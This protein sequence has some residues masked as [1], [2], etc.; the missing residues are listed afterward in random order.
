MA[1]AAPGLDDRIGEGSVRGLSLPRREPTPDEDSPD[2]LAEL[3]SSFVEP[4]REETDQLQ[5][6]APLTEE[7]A[8]PVESPPP[9][10]DADDMPGWLRDISQP[11]DVTDTSVEPGASPAV[12]GVG[13]GEIPTWLQEA[14]E[15]PDS[16]PDS[17][18]VD[19]DEVPE[20]MADLSQETDQ[21]T[22]SEPG[23]LPS[24]LQEA[25]PQDT[26]SDIPGAA[27]RQ[28]GPESGELPERLHEAKPLETPPDPQPTAAVDEG[29]DIEPAEL[30][31]WLREVAPK[32]TSPE[33]APAAGM[34]VEIEPGELPDWLQETLTADDTAIEPDELPDWLAQIT[35]EETAPEL[36]LAADEDT[37][38]EP[39]EL[40]DWLEKITPETEPPQETAS[41]AGDAETESGELPAW[42]DKIAPQET[43]PH[44][45][46]A[47]DEEREIEP[48]ELPDWLEKSEYDDTAPDWPEPLIPDADRPDRGQ[49]PKE[50][51]SEKPPPPASTIPSEADALT[52]WL[53]ATAPLADSQL[54]PTQPMAGTGPLVPP[55]LPDWL[56]AVDDS[57]ATR[58]PEWLV[59]EDDDSIPPAAASALPTPGRAQE[60]LRAPTDAAPQE[61]EA[62]SLPS[63]LSQTG[64]GFPPVDQAHALKP[65]AKT[66]EPSIAG[67]ATRVAPAGLPD[68]LAS[69]DSLAE[70]EELAEET[71][72]EAPDRPPADSEAAP[73][74]PELAQA[75]IPE[76]LQALKPEGFVEDV[77]GAAGAAGLEP[78]ETDGLLQGVRGALVA[79]A[80]VTAPPATTAPSRLAV[81][82]QQQ[83]HTKALE[84]IVRPGL[85]PKPPSTAARPAWERLERAAIPIV[86]FLAILLPTFL[87]GSPLTDGDASV[88]PPPGISDTF[89][90]IELMPDSALAVVAFDYSPAEA[91]ELEPLSSVLVR[92][93]MSRGE[94]I[95]AVSTT[96]TGSEIAQGVLDKLSD[97]YGYVYGTDYL[98]LGYIPGGAAGLQAF[99]AA[100]WRLF[101]GADYLRITR[102]SRAAQAASSL[103]DS[104]ADADLILI[105]T[106]ARD[107]LA[108]WIEQ[109]GRL[110]DME[111]VGMAAGVS[112][113]LEPWVRP[114]YQSDSP[115]LSGLV[116]GIPGASQYELLINQQY[117]LRQSHAATNVRDGQMVGL[118]AVSLV[119]AAGLVWGTASALIDRRRGNG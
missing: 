44:I 21:D 117:S 98:N 12:P 59:E 5:A 27:D 31:D 28:G 67:G 14:L 96:P 81:T 101:S 93:L 102:S 49:L 109:V 40:P 13:A 9:P 87:G 100:P 43:Q 111:K 85:A 107:D 15:K 89:N 8:S 52:D 77:A 39:D 112:A 3:R 62:D 37:E 115:Q 79:E 56:A 58:L 71:A 65:I 69:L 17:R 46:P 19:D 26:L 1:P 116:S 92:H 50:D 66:D 36:E 33:L 90:L 94:R 7:G 73:V 24:W 51:Q 45:P 113:G 34:G 106:A 54:A 2:W 114:Y 32:E 68:W 10:A 22:E 11:S 47:T 60:A 63:W 4:E 119:I 99:A 110:P 48:G 78:V 20:W 55:E 61:E 16:A 95:L 76:W 57:A 25:R 118:A 75:A 104:L 105:V 103:T 35:P 82:E 64:A 108:A 29:A 6:A 18:P 97:D 23:D 70:L 53:G 38:I 86:V 83:A 72:P 84:R 41:A 30:L 74:E 42:L 88:V 91:G 80:I